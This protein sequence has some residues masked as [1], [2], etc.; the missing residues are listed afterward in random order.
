MKIAC[1]AKDAGIV[2]VVDVNSRGDIV[3]HK[4]E[5]GWG[6]INLNQARLPE[7]QNVHGQEQEQGYKEPT[8]ERNEGTA[9][10]PRRKRADSEMA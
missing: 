6:W 3:F 2:R 4:V 9:T 5:A 1:S 7:S 10:Q 8:G